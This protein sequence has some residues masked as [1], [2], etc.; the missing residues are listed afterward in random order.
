MNLIKNKYE[1]PSIEKGDVI[2][3]WCS[4][5]KML[6]VI[7]EDDKNKKGWFIKYSIT[8]NTYSKFSNFSLKRI[9]SFISGLHIIKADGTVYKYVG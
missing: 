8:N 2:F 3:W 1:I 7:V 6:S 4:N 9:L 5:K